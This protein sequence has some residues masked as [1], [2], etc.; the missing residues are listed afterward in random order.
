[1]QNWSLGQ[2]S[3]QRIGKVWK[4]GIFYERYEKKTKE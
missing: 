2:I 4:K 1:M 3:Q